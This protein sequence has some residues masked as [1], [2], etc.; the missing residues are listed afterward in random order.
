M[1]LRDAALWAGVFALTW[2]EAVIVTRGGKADRA[3]TTC[4][5]WR[6]SLHAA[7]WDAAF[8]IIALSGTL[9]II[10]ES[11]W[12]IIPVVAGGWIGTVVELERRRKK[13][14]RNAGRLGR[15]RRTSTN[16]QSQSDVP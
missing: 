13:F 11:K 1:S 10:T 3:S 12:L 14:R 2:L 9:L 7:N 6:R 15:R 16:I 8:E 5:T 4:R